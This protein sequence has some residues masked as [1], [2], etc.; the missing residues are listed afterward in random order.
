MTIRTK[1]FADILE[2]KFLKL[3]SQ[4]HSFFEYLIIFVLKLGAPRSPYN[5]PFIPIICTY[6]LQPPAY[7]LNRMKTMSSSLIT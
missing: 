4:F 7:T 1:N 6:S 2:M 5:I 3:V